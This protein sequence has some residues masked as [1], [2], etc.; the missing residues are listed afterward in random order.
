MT[1]RPPGKP[2][3]PHRLSDQRPGPDLTPVVDRPDAGTGET[4]LQIEGLTHRYDGQQCAVRDLSISVGAGEV[5]GLL[6]PSGCGK[7]TTLRLAAGL[8][9]LQHGRVSIN[10][11]VVSDAAG[12]V[13]PEDRGV[14]LVFQD[15]ALFPHLSVLDNI[16]FGIRPLG[17]ARRRA[18]ALE[19]LDRVRMSGYENAYPHTLSGG[20]QQRIALAR[21]LAPEPRVLLLDEPY[22]SIEARL[23][24]QIRDDLLHL[25]KNTDCATLIVTHDSEEA[26]FMADRIVVM[27]DGGI[28]QSGTPAHLYNYPANAFV[29]GIFSDVNRFFGV[30]RD[31]RVSTPIGDLPSGGLADDTPVELVIR[32][33]AIRLR[34]PDAVAPDRQAEVIAAR[35]LGRTSLIHLFF[36]SGPSGQDG[37]LHLHARMPGIVLPAAGERFAVDLDVSQAFVFPQS[38]A[39]GSSRRRC[40]DNGFG[41]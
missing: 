39:A 34:S 1:D 35:M 33:E 32:P 17:R 31:G 36:A 16:Q 13:P 10:G 38:E 29:A 9:T 41:A 27:R 5:V 23:R 6:G 11:R 8:E 26:M 21:A 22:S 18:R 40:G 14:G 15:Y 2:D 24:D 37:P 30:S 19:M 3:V 12:Q 28:V 4:G 25:L 7:S 20:Q